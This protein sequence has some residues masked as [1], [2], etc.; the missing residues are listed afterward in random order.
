MK[1]RWYQIFCGTIIGVG[2][3]LRLW[4]FYDA[5]S[6]FLDEANLALNIAELSYADFFYPLKYQQYAPPL[7]VCI[8]KAST[9]LL[10]LNEWALRLPALIFGL[11]GLMV[12][13]RLLTQLMTTLTNK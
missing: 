13:Y 1:M 9:V 6:L 5:R 12:F 11:L 3:L 2:V 7:F 10:G 8:V 4:W